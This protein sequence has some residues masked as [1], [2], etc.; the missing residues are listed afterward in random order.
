MLCTLFY[1]FDP[2]KQIPLNIPTGKGVC[3][4]LQTD[5]PSLQMDDNK[6]C[7]TKS[8]YIIYAVIMYS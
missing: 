8:T 6:V 7:F 2:P 1:A 5:N 3:Y 4:L